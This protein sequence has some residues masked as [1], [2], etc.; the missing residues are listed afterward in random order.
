VLDEKGISLD[1]HRSKGLGDVPIS[2][3]DVVVGMEAG[4]VG[5]LPENFKGRLIEWDIPDPFAGDV[6]VFRAVRDLIEDHVKALLAEVC[7][8]PSDPPRELLA[9]PGPGRRP[10][11]KR[12]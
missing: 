9:P 7:P 4:L 10:A 11:A 2:E 3:M 12:D 8:P 5:T 1:S 6:E